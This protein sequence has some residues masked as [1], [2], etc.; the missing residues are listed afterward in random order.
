[1]YSTPHGLFDSAWPSSFGI[2]LGVLL[3]LRLCFRRSPW[4]LVPWLPLTVAVLVCTAGL[5]LGAVAIL[6]TPSQPAVFHPLAFAG[7]VFAALLVGVVALPLLW[8][9]RPDFT[10]LERRHWTV[11]IIAVPCVAFAVLSSPYLFA[12]NL[13]I[14]CSVPEGHPT[15]QSTLQRMQENE[16]VKYGPP[17]ES[18]GGAFQLRLNSQEGFTA[19]I[20][21]TGY[22][23]QMINIFPLRKQNCWLVFEGGDPHT[24]DGGQQRR[25]PLSS[26]VTLNLRFE[27]AKSTERGGPANRSQLVGSETNRTSSAA[28]SGG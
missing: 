5:L 17:V 22:R 18:A 26:P 12:H 21:A 2:V 19:I 11:S 7:P 6:L 14:H 3:L 23:D 25:V 28:G 1:M 4:A 16:V 15:P 8:Y 24:F 13:L 20:S 9:S 27:L 10:S